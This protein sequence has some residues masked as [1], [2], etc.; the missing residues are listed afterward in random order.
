M[1]ASYL[2]NTSPEELASHIGFVRALDNG[3][4]SVDFRDQRE[5]EYTEL[6]VVAH[7]RQGLLS[8]IAGVMR[9]MNVNI[10]AAQI[11]TRAGDPEIAIDKLFVDCE[12][13]RLTET[14][15]WQIE[16]GLLSVLTG[17]QTVDQM[18]ARLGRKTSIALEGV[19]VRVLENLSDHQTVVEVRAL[20]TYGLLHH[21]TCTLSELGF[22]I[23][24][25][26]VVTWGHEARDVFYVTTRDGRMLTEQQVAAIRTRLS[27]S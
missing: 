19:S 2:L 11:Y 22:D 27:D 20:D 3:S 5:R 21:L 25:A 10:H 26:R 23:H 24:S 6:T 8:D 16:D 12:G 7:D 13:R 15:K 9:S 4:P 14:K 1:P 17:S 18:L